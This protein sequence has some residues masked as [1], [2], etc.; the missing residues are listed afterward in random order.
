[1]FSVNEAAIEEIC[2]AS[3]QSI[4]D[5]IIYSKEEPFPKGSLFVTCSGIMGNE[6]LR[7]FLEFKEKNKIVKN[8]FITYKQSVVTPIN[9]ETNRII[10]VP[11]QLKAITS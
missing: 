6:A 5:D 10:Q 11:L 7:M 3:L 4:E 1:M 8:D 9:V 2:T